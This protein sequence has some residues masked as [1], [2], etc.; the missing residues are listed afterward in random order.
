[1]AYNRIVLMGNLTAQPELRKTQTG[2]SV[3]SFTVAVKRKM[4]EETDFHKCLAW[5]KT[6]EAIAKYMDK[7]NKILVEGELH[8]RK[9]EANGETKYITEVQVDSFSFVEKAGNNKENVGYSA[10]VLEPNKQG[11]TDILDDDD[12]LPF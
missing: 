11:Y 7:G 12:E 5:G 10:P 8:H 6:G 4:Q 2:K 3:C 1:M 9:Y